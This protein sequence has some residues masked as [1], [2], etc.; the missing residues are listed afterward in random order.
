M[1]LLGGK[2]IGKTL[3]S[4]PSNSGRPP[5]VQYRYYSAIRYSLLCPLLRSFAHLPNSIPGKYMSIM[6]LLFPLWPTLS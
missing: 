4:I 3:Q 1:V 5:Y 6:A 2:M